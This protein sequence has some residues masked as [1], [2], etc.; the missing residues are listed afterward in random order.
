MENGDFR[1][2]IRF[3]AVWLMAVRDEIVDGGILGDV[4]EVFD[5]ESESCFTFMP[6]LVT[7]MP[8]LV[9]A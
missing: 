4:L 6:G 8:V 3:H 5:A 1:S 2:A 7:T 9:E